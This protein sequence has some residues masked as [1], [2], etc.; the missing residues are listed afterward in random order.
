MATDK[1]STVAETRRSD[2]GWESIQKENRKKDQI[3]KSSWQLRVDALDRQ[4]TAEE[5]AR[6]IYHLCKHRG[7]H[8]ISR[9]EENAA[10]G[11]S[12]SESGRVKQGLAGTKKLM[13]EKNYRTAAEMV[14]TEFPEAQRNKQG[15]YSKALSRILLGDEFKILFE[16][17]RRLKNPFATKVLE[18]A[19]LGTGDHKSGLFWAQNPAL[20]GSDLLKML[21][22]CTFEKMEYRAPKASFTAERHV[23]LTRLNN[24]RIVVDGTTRP[25]NEVERRIALSMPYQQVGDLTYKQL[26]AALTKADYL[27]DAFRYTGLSYASGNKVD[28]KA[29]DPKVLY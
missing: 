3:P 16:M 21:G 18:A 4:L 14:L 27:P 2:I 24:L 20:A 23:W 13:A 6:V 29:K 28:E 7:F 1:V 11:D 25:L 12:K 5:W 22:H 19:I 17:Q 15:D 26:R 9:A 10:E 8:W